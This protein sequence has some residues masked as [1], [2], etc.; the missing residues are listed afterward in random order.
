MVCVLQI[1]V[2]D[3]SGFFLVVWFDCVCGFGVCAGV[4]FSYLI[5]YFWFRFLVWY[6]MDFVVCLGSL[7]VAGFGASRTFGFCG[8]WLD[9]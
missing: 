9:F 7:F 5:W 4:S 2:G 1:L 8:F 6:N 3:W